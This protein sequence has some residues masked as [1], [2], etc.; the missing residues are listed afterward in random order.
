L[1]E[2]HSA[3]L[4]RDWPVERPVDA[5]IHL[6]GLAAVGPSFASPQPYI[7]TNSSM[8][9]HMCEALLAT[10]AS[11]RVIGVSSGAVY[12]STGGDPVDERSP[13]AETSPYVVS[14]LVIEHQLAYYARR[15]LDTV[16]VRPF[17][18]LGP[19]QAKGYLLPDL[20]AALLALR[21]GE[22]LLAG[23]LTTERDYTD[24]R[25]VAAAYLLLAEADGH[26]EFVYNIASGRSVPGKAI[27]AL[28]V[29]ALGRPS[30]E[31][32]LDPARVRATDARRICGSSDRFRAEFGWQPTIPLERS[33]SD[34]V[35]SGFGTPSAGVG[36]K[37]VEEAPRE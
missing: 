34:F 37:A 7:E 22:Q 35:A 2:Y 20:T 6:A 27:L 18:H 29:A 5:V 17:N 19:G 10:G 32:T 9:T 26:R 13:I 8:V 12:E 31:V 15:G 23:D 1:A 14:K 25:D 33:V 3:D 4:R 16:V 11:S 28:A 36:P 21:A 24:V 30:P